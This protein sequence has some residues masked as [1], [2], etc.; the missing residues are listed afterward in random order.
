MNT[1]HWRIKCDRLWCDS[2][3]VDISS[4][5]IIVVA[6]KTKSIHTIRLKDY[7]FH[8]GI[9][10]QNTN[11]YMNFLFFFLPKNSQC[12]PKSVFQFGI[13][14]YTFLSL[15]N[16]ANF[17]FCFFSFY[18]FL[19]TIWRR[20]VLCICLR[21]ISLVL[22]VSFAYCFI[23][24]K[25]KRVLKGLPLTRQQLGVNW[26][27]RFMCFHLCVSFR[28]RINNRKLLKKM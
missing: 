13:Y 21:K 15:W 1:K 22:F 7:F 5:R 16:L 18:S 19:S 25:I 28:L 17:F 3:T 11:N 10:T 24:L 14:L 8:F 23:D 26:W 6:S 12:V 9:S 27:C 2:D 4:V 20:A